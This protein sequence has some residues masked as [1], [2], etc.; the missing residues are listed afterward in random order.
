MTAMEAMPI[1]FVGFS[2]IAALTW[3]FSYRPRLFVRVFVPRDDLRGAIRGILRDPNFGRGMRLLPGSD[4]TEGLRQFVAK[5][6]SS[7]ERT[8]NELVDSW[9][10][11]VRDHGEPDAS[12]DR[13]GKQRYPGSTSHPPPRQ[14]SVSFGYW[15]ASRCGSGVGGYRLT[16]SLPPG[17]ANG[18]ATTYYPWALRLTTSVNFVRP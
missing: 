3:F 4:S 2:S 11:W 15:R 6:L 12:P 18:Y 1:A 7:V 8:G 16:L 9:L 5:H 10:E 14:V 13:G 17:I